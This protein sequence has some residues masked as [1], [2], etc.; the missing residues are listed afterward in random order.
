MLVEST[1]IRNLLN[2]SLLTSPSHP[3]QHPHSA[4]NPRWTPPKTYS[5]SANPFPALIILLLGL[6][7]SSHHQAS[8]VSTMLHRQWGTLFV[9]F[10]LARAVTYILTYLSP[11]SSYL[12]S[13]PPSELVASF[14]LIAG[15]LL[16]MA[17][18]RDTV[19]AM[20][21]AGVGAMVVFMVAVGGTA[22]LMAW[23]IVVVAVKGWAV[24]RG[25]AVR[26]ARRIG[27]A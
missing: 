21:R 4:E 27:A 5:I 11:P 23:V 8:P 19:S 24:R 17:S 6:T 26:F 7:M 20:E 1:G 16:F 25:P 12:P 14:C 15:G 18:N 13:R 22:V 10:A 9:G 3:N 2:T